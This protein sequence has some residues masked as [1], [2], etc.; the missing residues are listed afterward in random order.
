LSGTGQAIVTAANNGAYFA[1]GRI[2][3]IRNKF[4]ITKR[5]HTV[6]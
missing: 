1:Y 3:Y 5:F 2:Q 4:V 6:A